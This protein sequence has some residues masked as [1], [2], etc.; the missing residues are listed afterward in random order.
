[1]LRATCYVLRVQRARSSQRRPASFVRQVGRARDDLPLEHPVVLVEV[2]AVF[3]EARSSPTIR[4][5]DRWPEMSDPYITACPAMPRCSVVNRSIGCASRAQSLRSKTMAVR[6]LG[7]A[8]FCTNRLRGVCE[9]VP[10]KPG[11]VWCVRLRPRRADVLTSQ[12]F[13]QRD[14]SCITIPACPGCRLPSADDSTRHQRAACP[15]WCRCST[16]HSLRRRSF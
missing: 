12:R 11:P 16:P 13:T 4:M 3:L 5:R 9:I 7:F 6:V 14:R 10:G 8:G 1:V 2:V 15:E